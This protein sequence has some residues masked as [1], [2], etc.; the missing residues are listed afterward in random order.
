MVVVNRLLDRDFFPKA[1][2][3]PPALLDDVT[4]SFSSPCLP[5]VER[6]L[7]KKCNIEQRFVV[8]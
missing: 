8:G 3:V 1:S 5:T 7:L 2:A 4:P 6:K